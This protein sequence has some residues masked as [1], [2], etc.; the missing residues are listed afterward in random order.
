MMM[1][2]RTTR[3][4][5]KDKTTVI[6]YNHEHCMKVYDALKCNNFGD[7]HMSYLYCDALLL[8][9]VFANFKKTCVSYYKLDPTYYMTAQSLAWDAMLLQ[10]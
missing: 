3:I 2:K 1:I 9:D 10:T 4:K 5:R 7:Y 6:K 8:A